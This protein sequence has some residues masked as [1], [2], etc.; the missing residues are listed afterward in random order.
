MKPVMQKILHDPAN[1]KMGDCFRACVCSLLEISDE[2]VPNFGEYSSDEWWKRFTGWATSK[3]YAVYWGTFP[4]SLK[5][6][7]YFIA[8]GKS[9][10][11]EN[12]NHSVVAKMND[13]GNELIFVHDPNPAGGG[14]ERPYCDYIWLE[15]VE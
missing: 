5:H 13:N 11:F 12:D 4:P 15:K 6:S 14:I 7:E 10:R 8:T 3:G 1:G 2:N 9:P